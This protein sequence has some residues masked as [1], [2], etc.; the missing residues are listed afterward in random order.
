MQDLQILKDRLI[1]S[2]LKTK[3]NNE[4]L[5]NYKDILKNTYKDFSDKE[6]TLL[7][8]TKALMIL[9]DI[10]KELEL[11]S[12]YPDLFTK[13]IIAV[14][15]G[16]SVGK[17]RFI[18]S[19]FDDENL[20]LPINID[21]TT[22]IPTYVLNS[23]TNKLLA[24][25]KQGASIDLN[26]IAP[27]F[28]KYLTH[29]FLSLFNFNPKEIMP[30]L[31][32]SVNMS[33]KKDI[34][35]IDTPGYNS[36][37]EAGGLMMND[38]RIAK[39]YISKSSDVIWLI[40]DGVLTNSDCDFIRNLR[41][42]NKNLYIV[43]NQADKINPDKLEEVLKHIDDTCDRND[44]FIQGISAYSSKHKKEYCY[45]YKSLDEFINAKFEQDSIYDSIQ[46]RLENVHLMYKNSLN[47][48][49]KLFKSNQDILGK[50]NLEII[51]ASNTGANIENI[52][53]ELETIRQ[54]F[55]TLSLERNLSE[56]DEIFAKFK[57][58]IEQIFSKETK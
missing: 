50:V 23:D 19:F 43:L 35:F 15:G 27:N 18:S 55:N 17:S 8:K 4:G 52:L 46:K 37:N 47:D 29:E 56:V 44:I 6:S 1:T 3:I 30:Y 10:E 40:S 42:K 48:K 28:H 38:L 26:K 31:I 21:P 25:N 34:C 54:Q 32:Y 58:S 57:N 20:S 16:F 36:S 51:K 14:G 2:L 11:S 12:S 7:E 22:A 24:C 5:R 33:S 49:I 39:E 13:K 9:Q 41:L 45:L 53:K